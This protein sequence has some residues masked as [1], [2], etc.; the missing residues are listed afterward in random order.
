VGFT[1][2][3]SVTEYVKESAQRRHENLVALAELVDTGSKDADRSRWPAMAV[4]ELSRERC[5]RVVARS[6]Q[7]FERHT[8]DEVDVE[9]DLGDL[10]DPR[11]RV[12][13]DRGAGAS[14]RRPIVGRVLGLCGTSRA[15]SS[16]ARA[17]HPQAAGPEL[18]VEVLL[19]RCSWARAVKMP[20]PRADID[21]QQDQQP[22]VTVATGP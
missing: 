12:A 19:G 18:F 22:G 13:G 14:V 15:S 2:S 3:C 7:V 11:P 9:P 10:D 6:L 5:Q 4:S 20:V 1:T 21:E 17:G 8:F 16:I